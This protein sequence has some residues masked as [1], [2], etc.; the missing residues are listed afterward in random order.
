[1]KEKINTS[2]AKLKFFLAEGKYHAIY[3]QL[4]L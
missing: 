1:M 3:L 2:S 4:D